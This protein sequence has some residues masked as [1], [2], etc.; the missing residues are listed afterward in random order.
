MSTALEPSPCSP[1]A[2][3]PALLLSSHCDD[4]HFRIV[5]SGELDMMTAPTLDHALHEADQSDRPTVALD[6]SLVSF[7]DCAGMRVLI[8]H[9]HAL[10]EAGRLLWIDGPSRS[11]LRVAAMTGLDHTL[12]LRPTNLGRATPDK[13]RG[14]PTQQENTP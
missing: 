11:V 14:N 10:A 8:N 6:L 13:P 4:D 3:Q 12:H 7:C 5:A 2:D 1:Q 9:H